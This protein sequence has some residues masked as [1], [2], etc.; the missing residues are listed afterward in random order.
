MGYETYEA[1]VSCSFNSTTGHR[2]F[3]CIKAQVGR[4]EFALP[5]GSGAYN[6][7]V[8]EF[9]GD[10]DWTMWE[11]ALS[12]CGSLQPIRAIEL[13]EDDIEHLTR[14]RV[15]YGSSSMVSSAKATVVLRQAESE[16]GSPQ[17]NALN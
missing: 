15:P 14:F 10:A 2:Y 8:T 3:L 13:D 1:G 5:F 9:L 11:K 17:A 16:S 7:I 4:L 6:H 12:H